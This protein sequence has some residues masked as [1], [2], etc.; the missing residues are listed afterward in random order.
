MYLLYSNYMNTRKFER[1]V[2]ELLVLKLKLAKLNQ[3]SDGKYE[4]GVDDVFN[5][6]N[7]EINKLQSK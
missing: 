1:L 2:L 7:S 3:E 4:F 6:I 5:L